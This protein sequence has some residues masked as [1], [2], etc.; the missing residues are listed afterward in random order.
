MGLARSVG[1][2]AKQLAIAT[3][4]GDVLTNSAE[5]FGLTTKQEK[6]RDYHNQTA[7]AAEAYVKY[8]EDEGKGSRFLRQA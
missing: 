7:G 4:V 6:I 5:S 3:A 1:R 8:E 2:F